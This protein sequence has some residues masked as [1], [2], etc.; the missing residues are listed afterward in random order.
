MDVDEKGGAVRRLRA[1]AQ[2]LRSRRRYRTRRRDRAA[3]LRASAGARRGAALGQAAGV[4]RRRQYPHAGRRDA[5][6]TRS[7]SASSPTRRATAS[8]TLSE[9]SGLA[10]HLRHQRHRGRRR[11][12]AGARR[13]PHHAGRRRLVGGVAAGV[14]AARGAARHRRAHPRRRQAQGA[15]RPRR[16]VLHHRGR[17]QRQ[18]RGRVA[19]GRRSRAGLEIRRDGRARARRN[20]PRSRTAT[21][22]AQGIALTPLDAHVR[23]PTASSTARSSVEF[24]RAARLATITLRGPAAPPP[25]SA[26]AMAA[27]GAEFWPLQARA[28]TRRRD[29]QH[30]AQRARCRGDRVQIV[31]R[32]GGRCSPT[33]ISSMPTR[34]IGWRAKSAICGSACSSASISPRARWSR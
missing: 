27:L 22:P 28:R 9:N 20:L 10:I 23:A 31:R 4:L 14:A 30:P 16:R 13:R 26:D 33:T 8:R 3:A 34:I 25:A 5:T 29:P 11:L 32:S 7:I 12:R 17:R 24:D 19:A 18:A 15:P 2:F 1:E 21:A 6:P